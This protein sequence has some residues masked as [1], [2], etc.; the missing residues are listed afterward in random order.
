MLK[1]TIIRTIMVDDECEDEGEDEGYFFA[2]KND[3]DEIEG[4]MLLPQDNKPTA[5]LV[6]GDR[7][8]PTSIVYLEDIPKLVKA[9]NA[10][11][12]KYQEGKQ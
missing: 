3:S 7:R 8:D 9:L 4:V 5:G 1:G 6:V 10:A 11:Y 12:A 2:Y